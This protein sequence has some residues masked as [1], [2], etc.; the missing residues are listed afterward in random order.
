MPPDYRP[1]RARHRV[2][3]RQTPAERCPW[4]VVRPRVRAHDRPMVAQRA[5]HVGLMRLAPNVYTR[6]FGF[7]NCH[8]DSGGG[9]TRRRTD[10]ERGENCDGDHHSL[11][12]QD[13]LVTIC[14]GVRSPM[15][16]RLRG[17]SRVVRASRPEAAISARF[18]IEPLGTRLNVPPRYAAR[19][20]SRK[21]PRGGPDSAGQAESGPGIVVSAE[22]QGW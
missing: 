22:S 21:A 12:A 9:T 2:L 3:A 16:C 6:R 1:D 18:R 5:R 8:S 13:S 19:R 7:P 4:H 15:F 11:P 14:F 10:R 17:R 20:P